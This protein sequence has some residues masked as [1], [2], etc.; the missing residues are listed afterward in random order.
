MSILSVC[1]SADA[2]KDLF[3]SDLLLEQSKLKTFEQVCHTFFIIKNLSHVLL[4]SM[5]NCV[6]QFCPQCNFSPGIE[7]SWPSACCLL[8]NVSLLE[9]WSCYI[10][11]FAVIS[12]ASCLIYL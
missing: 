9:S 7:W 5:F 12:I 6:H 8:V 4:T 1:V 11:L 2:V 3:V 10:W